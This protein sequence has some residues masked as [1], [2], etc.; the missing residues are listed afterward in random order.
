MADQDRCGETCSSS[1]TRPAVVYFPA[2]TYLVSSSIVA[3]YNTQMIGNVSVVR[4]INVNICM[5]TV[6]VSLTTVQ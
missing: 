6:F 5:L 2:G 3:Y 4:L 1:T